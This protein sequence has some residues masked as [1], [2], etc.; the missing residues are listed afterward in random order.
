VVPIAEL[1]QLEMTVEVMRYP[2]ERTS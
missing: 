1:R 2:A